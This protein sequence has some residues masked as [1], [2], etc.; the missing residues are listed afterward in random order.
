MLT[1]RFTELL[2]LDIEGAA[3]DAMDGEKNVIRKTLRRV[4]LM[5]LEQQVAFGKCFARFE[6]NAGGTVTAYFED[7]SSATGDVLVGA[8]G[9]GSAVRK[10]RLPGAR[11]EDTGIVSLGGKLPM[12]AQCRALL[13]A[14]MFQGMSMIMAPKGFG[15]I[16]HSLEF[17][18]RQGNAGFVARWPTFAE[19]LDVDSV[20]WAVWGA[21]QN[22]PKDPAS[23]SGQELQQLGIELTAQ[24]HPNMR[25]L[26]TMTDPAAI[27]CVGMRTSIPVPS[28]ESTNVTLLG[29]AIHT[30]TPGR[31][32][33]ANTAL[34]DA[35]LLS[36]RLI[37]V[38][39]GQKPLLEAI[40][41]YEVEMRRY[42]TEAVAESKKHVDSNALIHRPVVGAL[43][44]ALIRSGMR[45]INAAPPLKRR[46]L[47]NILRVRGAN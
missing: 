18:Q 24:W 37:E 35:A 19:W 38:S 12:T 14:T 22:F 43:Q 3:A 32:A 5:G 27:H 28:W 40:H 7:G 47:Q 30:M 17:P 26:I 13:S 2:R 45:V 36:Q 33:G 11:L 20:G 15:G 31:G 39:Q 9:S 16:I 23:L 10:Q 41:D 6:Q 25:A 42:S 4:L 34:R 29:D 44:L 1:E 21:R 8:D 46:I